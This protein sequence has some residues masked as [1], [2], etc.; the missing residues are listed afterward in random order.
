[1]RVDEPL[2]L[3]APKFIAAVDVALVPLKFLWL[4]PKLKRGIYN[5]SY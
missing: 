3:V 2:P 5:I 1:M 4:N